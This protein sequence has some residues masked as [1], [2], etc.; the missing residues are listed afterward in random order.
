MK[1]LKKLHLKSVSM[2]LNDL[3]MK[4]IVGGGGIGPACDCTAD[5]CKG[6]CPD[7]VEGS[8]D[9]GFRSVSQACVGQY[10]WNADHTVGT[11]FCMCM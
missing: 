7:R 4:Q 2:T 10:V 11:E 3:E 1:T 9:G 8:Y 5:G 6:A